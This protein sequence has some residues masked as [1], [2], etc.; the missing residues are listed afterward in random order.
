MT[1]KMLL[2]ANAGCML[3]VGLNTLCIGSGIIFAICIDRF[4][5]VAEYF[6]LATKPDRIYKNK[7]VELYPF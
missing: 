2:H 5:G 7:D 6:L 4:A 1:I 3:Y